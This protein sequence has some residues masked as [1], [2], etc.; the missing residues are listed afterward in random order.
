MQLSYSF[1]SSFLLLLL[2]GGAGVQIGKD[3]Q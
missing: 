3:D 2:H 1:D